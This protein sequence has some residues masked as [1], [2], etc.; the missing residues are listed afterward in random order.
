MPCISFNVKFSFFI[1]DCLNIKDRDSFK[2]YNEYMNLLNVESKD[3]F[4]ILNKIDFSTKTREIALD[5]FRKTLSK[6]LKVKIDKNHFLTANSL[7]LS[8]E[9]DKYLNF[10]SYLLFKAEEI[11]KIKIGSN[12]ISYLKK[13]MK[14]DLS[15]ESIK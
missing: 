10:N 1:F 9:V 15:I 11:K 4:Y 3:N 2:I 8:K 5:N 13:E 14:K 6:E 12:F 7:L